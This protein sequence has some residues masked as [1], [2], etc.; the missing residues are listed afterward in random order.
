MSEYDVSSELNLQTIRFIM[1]Y[2]IGLD[3]VRVR[4]VQ[5]AVEKWGERFL[6]RVYTGDEIT[7]CFGKK[8]PHLPLA[9]RFEA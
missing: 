9:A 1:I 4:R 5:D 8:N 2:G 6:H 7:Y 3:I